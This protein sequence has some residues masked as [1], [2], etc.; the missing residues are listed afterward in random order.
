M[1]RSKSW[2]KALETMTGSTE[3]DVGP[4]KEY[5][6]PL[7]NWLIQQRCVKKYPIGWSGVNGP[8]YDPC[9]PPT[10]LP[11]TQAPNNPRAKAHF[12]GV[13]GTII[14]LVCLLGH[15]IKRLAI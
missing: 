14:A 9:S 13:Y 2:P 3:L 10:F 12:N 11:K 6:R 1:G 5:F 8:V 7:R 15:V 4:L